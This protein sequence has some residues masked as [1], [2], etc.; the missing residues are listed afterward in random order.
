MSGE[1]IERDALGEVRV[2]ADAYWS[3]E[4][5]RAV[6]NF[7]VSGQ[8]MPARFVAAL[9]RIKGAAAATNMSLG[10]L[11]KERGDALM[12]AAAQ[13]AAGELADQFPVDVFQTGSGTSTNMNMNEVLANHASVLLGK[14]IGSGYVDA[15]DHVN[16]G[17]SSNDTIPTA[18][19]VSVA[20]GL[21]EHLIP[22]LQQL[23]RALEGKAEEFD[24]VLKSGR[25]H[26][27]DAAP[28]R[29][30]QEFSGFARQVEFCVQRSQQAVEGLLELALGGTAVGTGLNAH[31]KFAKKTISRLAK[32]SGLAFVEAKNHFEAQSAMDRAVAASG[33]LRTNAVALFKIAND[34]RWLGSGPHNGIGEIRLPALQPGSS[35]M[36]GKVNPVMS[37]S[38]MMVCCQVIGNDAAVAM[39]GASGSFELNTFLPLLAR[40][41]LESIEILGNAC[42]NFEERCIRGIEADEEQCRLTIERNTM[43]VTALAP[44]IGHEKAAELAL[45]AIRSG[46]TIRQVAMQE[47]LLPEA[48]L[49]AALDARKM[50][51]PGSRG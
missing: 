8:R 48:E 43:L 11:D 1:R 7:P 19:H 4:T 37:E 9:A 16:I 3:A 22:I 18:L 47:K 50:T 20:L 14:E 35:I 26:L 5:Q 23:Q 45:E 34:V 12:R 15:H 17:Q 6:N 40:N 21:Q 44:V 24:D 41:L 31:P 29:L 10:R 42:R 27:Q 46:K 30:G 2:P 25:T 39:G 33:A 28:V 32:D 36:P 49:D 38:L 13:I 51:E